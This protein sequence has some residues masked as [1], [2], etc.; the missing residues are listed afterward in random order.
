MF[1]KFK[2]NSHPAISLKEAE[3]V[4]ALL[5]YTHIKH[6]IST[7]EFLAAHNIFICRIIWHR[8]II[9]TPASQRERERELDSVCYTAQMKWSSK[10]HF[11][12]FHG[13][14]I[15]F[16]TN[17]VCWRRLN[18]SLSVLSVPVRTS[19]WRSTTFLVADILCCR[20]FFRSFVRFVSSAFWFVLPAQFGFWPNNL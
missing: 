12:T 19:G 3:Y 16:L 6:H 8:R 7:G 13:F 18:T 2:I 1:L 14:H 20:F 5:C 15:L 10:W 4:C 11:Y 9:Y 17:S